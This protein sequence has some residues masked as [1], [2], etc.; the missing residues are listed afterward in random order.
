M[1]QLFSWSFRRIASEIFWPLIVQKPHI[2]FFY[3]TVYKKLNLPFRRV[4]SKMM[5]VTLNEYNKLSTGG[6]SLNSGSERPF[7]PLSTVAT[8]SYNVQVLIDLSIFLINGR[9]WKICLQPNL[10]KRLAN[11]CEDFHL[12]NFLKEIVICPQIHVL[13]RIMYD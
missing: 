9:L 8:F 10:S 13:K 4:A 7:H 1:W 2:F 6:Q 12:T 3:L 11:N 5:S